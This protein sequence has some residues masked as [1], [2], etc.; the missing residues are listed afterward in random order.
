METSFG[1]NVGDFKVI[2]ALVTAAR[3][4]PRFRAEVIEALR[5]VDEGYTEIETEK[6]SWAGAFGQAQFIPTSFRTLAA[7]GDGD[8]KKDVWHNLADV[9]ASAAKHLH[10]SGWRYGERWGREVKLPDNFDLNLLTDMKRERAAKSKTLAQ[11]AELGVRLPGG[12]ALPQDYDKPVTLIAPNYKPGADV[13][14]RSPI[15]VVYDNFWAI[16]N[17]NSSYKYALA[18]NMLADAIA[19]PPERQPE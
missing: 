17:Y 1:S 3:R 19:K 4:D 7:D 12:G 8:G 11:W 9:F 5:M 16:V 13:A 14:A 15:Y 10:D 18:V 6:A 2:P